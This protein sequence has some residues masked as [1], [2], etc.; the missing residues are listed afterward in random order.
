MG[1]GA[2][3]GLLAAGCDCSAPAEPRGDAGPGRD[4]GETRVDAGPRSDAGPEDICYTGLDEDGDGMVDEDCDCEPGETQRCFR[5]DPTLAGEGACR[6]GTQRCV[7]DFEFSGWD[8]C[9]GDGMPS[10]EDCDG[11]D[12]DC[13]GTVDEGCDCITDME[14]SCYEG[15]A[16]T[17]G[18]GSCV[19]GIERCVATATGAEYGDCMDWTGPSMELCDG[20]GDE[21]C[22][23]LVDEGCTCA[24]GTMRGCYGGP[25]GTSGIGECH[26]GNQ[27]CV[28]MGG[29]STWGMCSGE[30]RP[31][32][33]ACTGGRDEDCDGDVDCADSDCA[34]SP[35]CCSPYNES[36]PV[37]PAQGEI[38][39]IVD[40]SG[41]MDWPAVGTT[42]TRWQELQSAM[43]TVL[44]MLDALPMGML[45]FPSVTGT[46]EVGNCMVPS[47]PQVPIALGSRATILST[48]V[49]G[50]PRAGDTPTP[51]ACG[52]A[53]SYLMTA[54][55]GRERFAV[56][57]TDGLPEPNCG[58]TVPATVTAINDLHST[59]MMDI[60]VIGI[61]G[62]DP[63]G[64]TT[65]IPA[66][67]AALNMFADAGGRPRSG[68]TRY[69]EA[70]DG[71]A[72]TTAMR[73]ILAA[74]TD[75]RFTLSTPPPDPLGVTVREDGLTV[76]RSTINGYSLSGTTLEFHGAYCTSIQAGLV[77]TISVSD[78]C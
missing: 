21:D 47:G 3:A 69:Y 18:V 8:V 64:D 65:G 2:L 66:L 7:S 61:V 17:E 9:V 42:R 6:W 59:L 14:R 55:T 25:P 63:S 35:A 1:L 30:A 31:G 54:P 56:L 72:L 70:T 16:G 48:L 13:D 11:V 76:P 19:P 22:D 28:T 36:L 53:Q 39:F 33:E 27:T 41:S 32:T 51:Q 71:A 44:P 15:P 77:T 73:T 29:V 46:S 52:V 23:G 67:Q 57:L 78:P 4:A 37:I 5:G 20:L 50:D 74:A 34:T 68:A 60:F 45:M 26:G 58:A 12:N 10:D 40:R 24:A 49:A 62:P 43:S 38:L 75:C